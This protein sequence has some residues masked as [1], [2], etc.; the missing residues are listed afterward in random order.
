[1]HNKRLNELIAP[2]QTFKGMFIFKVY[3]GRES[4]VS[5][6]WR[7]YSMHSPPLALFLLHVLMSTFF[8]ICDAII[9]SA[10]DLYLVDVT[11]MEFISLVRYRCRHERPMSPLRTSVEGSTKRHMIKNSVHIYVA[12][13]QDVSATSEQRIISRQ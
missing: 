10:V 3:G 11:C 7:C 8:S 4:E 1:M 2:E 12:L 13:G 6:I 9:L 5:D